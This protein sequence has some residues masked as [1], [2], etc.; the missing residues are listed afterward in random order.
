MGIIVFNGKSSRD[1]HVVVEH[2][3]AYNSPERDYEVT[4]IPGRNG[5]L[6][7]DNGGYTNVERTYEIAVDA[8]K[9]GF[10]RRVGAVM[11]WLRSASGYARL[12]D[13]YDRDYY[14]MACYSEASS[15]ENIENEAGRLTITFDCMPQ[16]FL[17]RG[18]IPVEFEDA[19]ALYNPTE[20]VAKPLIVVMAS[21]LSDGRVTVGDG[22]LTWDQR[23]PEIWY[24][25]QGNPHTTT[26]EVYE[27]TLDCELQDAYCGTTNWNKHVTG[28]FPEMQPGRN[29]V[30]FV[31]TESIQIIPRWWTI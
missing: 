10:S 3:P 21:N 5:D 23:D 31:G 13:S 26:P 9:E 28:K 11:S 2:P 16:R 4:Q 27:I 18:E 8:R 22:T 30:S 1:L 7:M 6:V 17:K 12:E 14:R 25:S 20:F 15:V 19:G 29:A 24:D